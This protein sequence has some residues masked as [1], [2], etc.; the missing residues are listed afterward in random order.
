MGISTAFDEINDKMFITHFAAV[1]GACWQ[2]AEDH[3]WHDPMQ[4]PDEEH[5]R[6]RSAG[7][8][9]ALIMSEGAEALEALREN[10]GAASGYIEV[11]GKPEGVIV[12][13]ADVIIRCMDYAVIHGNAEALAEWLLIKMGYN[14]TRPMKHGGKLI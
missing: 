13:L 3:G 14:H 8:E 9:I 1:A 2:I 7:E 11:D 5:P 10:K 6:C 4:F 12:E